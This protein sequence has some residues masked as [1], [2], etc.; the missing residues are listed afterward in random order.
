MRK[1]APSSETVYFR[2]IRLLML[3]LRHLSRSCHVL[4]VAACEDACCRRV[5]RHDVVVA[6]LRSDF[7]FKSRVYRPLELTDGRTDGHTDVT[8]GITALSHSLSLS[9]LRQCVGGWRGGFVRGGGEKLM[10]G[11]YLRK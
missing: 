2:L 4:Q 6:R 1:F 3:I 11:V 8:P 10:F 9:G 7:G 5:N